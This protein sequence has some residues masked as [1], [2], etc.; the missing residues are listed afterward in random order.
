MKYYHILSRRA[1]RKK[2]FLRISSAVKNAKQAELSL[3]AGG[4]AQQYNHFGKIS[5]Q[6]LI[7]LIICSGIKKLLI[8]TQ[9]R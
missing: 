8:N 4:N 3:I 9:N 6:F 5:W 2:K 7:K 1:K